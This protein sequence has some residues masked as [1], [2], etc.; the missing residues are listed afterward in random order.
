[1]FLLKT[2]LT[3]FYN[4]L[5]IYREFSFNQPFTYFLFHNHTRIVVRKSYIKNKD[6]GGQDSKANLCIERLCVS[7]TYFHPKLYAD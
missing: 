7:I 1:M 4:Q 5:L 6:K 2:E 3:K